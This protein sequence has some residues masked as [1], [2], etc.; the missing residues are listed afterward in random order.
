MG[1]SVATE[2]VAWGHEILWRFAFVR[3][4]GEIELGIE[5]GAECL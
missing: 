2:V 4:T 3:L 1:G 5:K